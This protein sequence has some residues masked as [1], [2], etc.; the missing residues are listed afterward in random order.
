M[1]RRFTGSLARVNGSRIQKTVK[2]HKYAVT[3]RNRIPARRRRI[4]QED[5]GRPRKSAERGGLSTKTRASEE[6][7][8]VD[9]AGILARA[10]GPERE[11]GDVRGER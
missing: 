11:F 9:E 2:G 3:D 7:G 5:E 8:P 1:C 10:R 4:R 6:D